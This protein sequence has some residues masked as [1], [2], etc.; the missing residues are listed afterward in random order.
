MSHRILVIHPADRSTR[1]LD[2]VYQNLDSTVV[3][4]NVERPQLRDL[5]EQ[6]DQVIMLGHGSSQGLYSVG[7]FPTYQY[8]VDSEL[9]SQLRERENSLYIWCYAAEFVRQHQL[10]GFATGMFISEVEEADWFRL[11]ATEAEITQSNDAFANVVG[12]YA[13]QHAQ[14]LYSA[15]YHQYGR[16]AR[17]N[18]V[19]RYNHARIRLFNRNGCDDLSTR[20]DGAAELLTV[21]EVDDQMHQVGYAQ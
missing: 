16:L 19:A 6:A 20:R 14:V 9:V 5:I 7:Q 21:A 8:V 4:G 3:T 10:C 2:L 15:L 12:Q 11:T 13:G 1:F 17:V 18:P